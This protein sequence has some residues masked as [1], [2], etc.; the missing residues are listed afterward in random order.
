M[1]QIRFLTV[2]FAVVLVFN[3]CSNEQ[4]NFENEEQIFNKEIQNKELGPISNTLYLYDI[5]NNSKGSLEQLAFCDYVEITSQTNGHQMRSRVNLNWT[6]SFN[7]PPPPPPPGLV[8]YTV[9]FQPGISFGGILTYGTPYFFE[10]EFLS[11]QESISVNYSS[12]EELDGNVQG[13]WRVRV[14][15]CEWS[16]WKDY[17]YDL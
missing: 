16:D 2:I 6:V 3:S 7:F 14:E 9:E 8:R 12:L 4:E 5:W 15:D 17:Y 11:T 1:K 10:E 13:R